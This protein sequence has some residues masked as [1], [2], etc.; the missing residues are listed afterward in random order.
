MKKII[1]IIIAAITVLSF[2]S[3]VFAAETEQNTTSIEYLEDGSYFAITLEDEM[4]S[5]GMTL[6]SSSV[7]KSKT[8]TYYSSNGEKKWYVKVTGSF[9]YGNGTSKC[10]KSSVTAGSYTDSWKITSKSASKNGSTA[11][12]KAT[13]KQYYNGSVIKTINKSIKLTCSATGKF[14]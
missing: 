5:N 7:T 13:A 11:T 6:L 3:T 12:A 10:T 4:P 2:T 14:S 8:Y 1:S 9:T